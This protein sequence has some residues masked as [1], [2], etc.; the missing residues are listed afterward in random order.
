MRLIFLIILIL[1]P[2]TYSF[3]STEC[4]GSPT[5]NKFIVYLHGMDS[6]SPSKQEL[7]NRAIL[8]NLAEKLNIRFALPRATQKC[9][10]NNQQICWTWAAKTHEDIS[11]V[12][13]AIKSAAED[14]FANRDYSVLGFSNGG[15]AVGALLRMCEKVSFKSAIIVGAAGGWF[16]TD[17]KNL[18]GCSPIII[19]LLGSEDQANQKYVREFVSH[20]ISLKAQVSLVEYKGDHR[21][22]F[23]PL[24]DLLK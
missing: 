3:G 7:G 21:L 14:C 24:A 23:E 6:V 20:L 11:I 17:P 15:V 10:V 12:Q 16:S 19:S 8:K 2:T 18:E 4:I 1:L 5:A 13:M 22:F 9:P